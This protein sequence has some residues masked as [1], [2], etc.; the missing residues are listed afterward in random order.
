M[1]AKLVMVDN[2]DVPVLLVQTARAKR[3]SITVKPFKPVRLTV[4]KRV[5]Q[6]EAREFLHKERAWVQKAVA[7][8][9]RVEQ[10]QRETAAQLPEI[11]RRKARRAIIARLEELAREH[12]FCYG[13]VSV[14]NQKTRWGSCS[15]EGNIN[16]NVNLVRLPEELRDYVLLHELVHTR[17]INHSAR[18]WAELDRYVGDAK[19]LRRRLKEHQLNAL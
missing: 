9:R 3:L 14:R 4:P 2:L 6:R 12:G 18:F 16:L 7:N 1:S 19:G 11:D 13:R 15:S 5:S 17:I 8:I 10:Q